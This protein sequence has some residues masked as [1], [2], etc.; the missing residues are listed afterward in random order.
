MKSAL[1]LVLVFTLVVPGL[2]LAQ[3]RAVRT[4]PLRDSASREAVRVPRTMDIAAPQATQV[5]SR[6]WAARHPVLTGTLIG[7]GVGFPIGAATCKY[8]TAEGSSCADY[9]FPGNARMLGGLTVGLY[10]AGIGAG[11]GA[12]VAVFRR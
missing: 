7:F 2:A 1:V 4:T 12:L 8:P 6:N 10:G 3:A 9:T 5:Q 11:V